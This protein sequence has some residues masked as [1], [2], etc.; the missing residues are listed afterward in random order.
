M[1]L[2]RWVVNPINGRK[3][4]LWVANYVLMDAPDLDGTMTAFH[5]V[6][7][8]GGVAIIIFSHPCFPQSYATV[9]E[10]G[11]QYR[12]DFPYFEQRKCIDPPWRHFTA[13]FIWFHRPLSDYWKAFKTA[14][15]DVVDFEEPRVT[16]DRYH[17]AEN[18]RMLNN[19]RNRPYS[20]AFK[21]QK[22]VALGAVRNSGMK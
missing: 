8:A 20:V 1:F 10:D 17:L 11:I 2:E 3:I 7:R 22:K 9:G 14:G 12:W 4:P 13:E 19:S 6:L 5:R 21:L 18:K 15:F 16:E